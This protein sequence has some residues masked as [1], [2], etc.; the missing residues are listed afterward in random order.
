MT[1][2]TN[3]IR[4]KN[5]NR[6]SVL[7]YIR[8]N[9]TATKAGLANATGLTFM[10]IKKILEELET[11]N[12]IRPDEMSKGGMGRHAAS[13]AVNENYKY[14]I[15]IHINKYATRVAVLN[16]RGEI[17]AVE[18]I[19]MEKD[20]SNQNAFVETLTSC[21]EKLILQ[22]RMKKEDIL[23]IGIGAPGP[24]DSE[25]GVILTPPNIPMLSYL[26]LKEVLERKTGFPVY[27]HKD[28]NAIAFGEYWYGEGKPYE[29]MVYIDVDMGIGS[30]LIIDGKLI[31]GANGIAGEFGH[32]VIDF[33]G[34]VCN[35]GNRGCLEA[36]SSGIAILKEL[37]GQLEKEPGHP[38]Y[39]KRNSLV[40]EDIF[41]MT[42]QNDL[43][44]ISIL[45]QSA[46]YMGIAVSNLINI[47][48]PQ[49][50]I[51]GGI[52]SRK[53][54][55]YFEIVKSVAESRKVKGARE[56]KFRLS[57][58]K[59]NAG[60]IGAGEIVSDHF[61]GEMVDEVFI[62]NQGELP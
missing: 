5:F 1:E 62:R 40:I 15:G 28:T 14:S 43:L 47:M 41:R 34:P 37:A 9:K 21:V 33:N 24:V 20:F 27:L 35:C 13:Y 42:E 57:G 58:L 54:P 25:N 23:G 49:V 39:A 19:S 18:E 22:E 32:I 8:K 45:N 16:L 11:L 4:L 6:R 36:M 55:R 2:Q 12:L 29:D 48:D 59:E 53:Y 61:F 3:Q 60:V 17:R 50:I 44:T 7:N 56:N 30:G 46:S 10:A 38:L 51:M 31:I 52:I 26:P